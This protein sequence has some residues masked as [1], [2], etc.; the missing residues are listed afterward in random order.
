MELSGNKGEFSKH[1]VTIVGLLYDPVK[2]LSRF[3]AKHKIGFTLLSDESS[4]VIREYGLLN[5]EMPK[6]TKYF[7]VPYPGVFLVNA[8]GQIVAKFAEKDYR[9]RPLLEDL[10]NAV[11]KLSATPV[12]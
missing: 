11:E 7:G 5:T 3:S 6:E 12:K 4:Q 10:L 2:Q 9:E 1:G 8:E